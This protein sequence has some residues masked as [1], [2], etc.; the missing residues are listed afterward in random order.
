MVWL[1]CAGF[2]WAEDG[3]FRLAVMKEEPESKVVDRHLVASVPLVE[4]KLPVRGALLRQDTE[5]KE[6]YWLVLT[7]GKVLDPG[8]IYILSCGDRAWSEWK[9]RGMNESD[10]ADWAHRFQDLKTARSVL[11]RIVK[12]H[13]LDPAVVSDA[14]KPKA[15]GDSPES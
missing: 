2:L 1:L 10:G 7:L 13:E 11:A 3:W 14:T 5:D 6:V 4:T 15:T 12:L 8:D 9:W